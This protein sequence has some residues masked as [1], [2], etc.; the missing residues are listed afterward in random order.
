MSVASIPQKPSRR[1][2]H[3]LNHPMLKD[4]ISL[5]TLVGSI[6]LVLVTFIMLLVKVHAVNY[7]VGVHFMSLVGFDRL[8]SWYEVYRFP[9]VGAMIVTING[10]LAAKSF[11]RNRLASF[12]LL[13]GGVSVALLCL[14]VS[15]AF[16][17]IT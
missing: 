3:W 16:A 8:G 14:V 5:I 15:R 10:L 2:A 4:P 7:K 1:L 9:V 17:V 6:A 13:L 12:F 11:Q